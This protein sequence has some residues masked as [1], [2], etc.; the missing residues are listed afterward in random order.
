M[1]ERQF[2]EFTNLGH[3]FAHASDVV[4]TDIVE[5]F[6]VFAVNRFS[7]AE[8]FR[9]R[10]DDA[11]F[12]R[13]SLDNLEFNRAH[14]TTSQEG[15]TLLHRTVRF[16]EVRLQVHVKQVTRD[17]FNRIPKRKH[18]HALTVFDIGTLFQDKKTNVKHRRQSSESL[19][20]PNFARKA[21]T[22]ESRAS[23]SPSRLYSPDARSQHLQ[24]ARASFSAQL[25]S[26][27]SFLPRSSHPPRRCTQSPF[28]FYP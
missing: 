20:I 13:I 23:S 17:A 28:S 8:D 24:V 3:L 27:E 4:V 9:I 22:R 2:N 10:C 19:S 26:F 18:V 5:A 15:V 25:C 1:S 6:F 16:Q 14:A 12:S 21:P 7:F 11:I